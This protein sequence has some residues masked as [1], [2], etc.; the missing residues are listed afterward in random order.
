[1]RQSMTRLDRAFIALAAMLASVPAVPALGQTVPTVATLVSVDAPSDGTIVTNG[2][3]VLVGGWA[4]D[5]SAPGTGV[6]GVRVYLDGRMEDGGTLLGNATYGESRP[7]VASALGNLGFTNS[8]FNYLWTPTGLTGGSHTLY[9]YAHSATSGWTSTSVQVSAQA[10]PTP[11]PLPAGRGYVPP[12]MY[13]G[14]YMGMPG[15]YPMPPMY[16]APNPGP[17]PGERVCIMIYP[18]PPGC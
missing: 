13:P 8:G 2:V 10:Q 15:P 5:P 18:P 7:D 17:P 14:P 4:A 11:T 9:V 12:P 16:P 6:D 3:T 1:M